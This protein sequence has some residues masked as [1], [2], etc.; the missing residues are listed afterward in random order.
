[1]RWYINMCCHFPLH[2]NGE[3]DGGA[4]GGAVVSSSVHPFTL[5]P[6]PPPPPLSL[7]LSLSLP[8]SLSLSLRLSFEF[9]LVGAGD[10]YL[11]LLRLMA[12]ISEAE[13]FP[14]SLRQHQ[15]HP[16]GPST[17]PINDLIPSIQ[18]QS[19]ENA[20]QRL[21]KPEMKQR[22]DFFSFLILVS[23]ILSFLPWNQSRN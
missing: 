7:S 9:E 3:G 21:S 12:S 15:L 20:V 17:G 10:S 18:F 11:L 19:A 6:Y 4:G 8:L 1:M 2:H 5:T 22:D 16:N 14:I 23:F 13:M